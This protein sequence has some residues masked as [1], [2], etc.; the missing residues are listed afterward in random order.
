MKNY[1]AIIAGCG[2]SGSVIAR[3][4]AQEAGKK[5][6]ILE[7]RKHIGGNLY[8]FRNEAGI[9]VHKYGPHAFHTNKKELF[10]YLCKYAQWKEFKLTCSVEMNGKLTP[11]PFNFQTIDDFYDKN[12]AAQIKDAL[13][14]AYPGQTHA[15]VL[16]LLVHPDAQIRTYARFL[17]DYDYSLY[18]AKQW[19]IP[20]SQIDPGVLRRVPVRLNDHREYFEDTWQYLP[21]DSY[22]TFFKQLLQHENIDICLGADALKTVTLDEK[23]HKILVDHKE[24]QGIFVYTG[25]IDE[26]FGQRYGPLPY[27]SLRF[28]W[29]TVQ[30]KSYQ[31]TPIVA[32]PQAQ[33]Y[34]RITEYTKMPKQ[35]TGNHTTYAVEYPVPYENSRGQEP[36]Y[37]VLTQDSKALYEQYKNEAHKYDS[38]YLC[39][40]LADFQYYNMDQALE[41]A[42]EVGKMIMDQ[43]L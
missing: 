43:Q 30:M 12:Q 8:D 28:E 34:T 29:K 22:T 27:R 9:L 16:D 40:R 36:Y 39:G 42:M 7:R 18:T 37:P 32:Y 3:T 26:L 20:P 33:G 38:L 2:L 11:S 10:A 15:F 24:F 4:I 13:Q 19:G 17:Y 41:R 21:V 5:V 23:K 6:L 14:K 1:D 25:A 35:D 31:Q